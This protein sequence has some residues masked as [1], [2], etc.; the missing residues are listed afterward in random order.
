MSSTIGNI[1]AGGA[2]V[3]G[4]RPPRPSVPVNP[5]PA[6]P[7]QADQ[8]PKVVAPKPVAIQFNPAEVRQNLK[9]AV[10]LLNQQMAATNRGLGFRM[11]DIMNTPVVTVRSD[12]TG[13]VVRQI[14]NEVVGALPTTLRRSR[15]CFSTAK[16]KFATAPAH[17]QFKGVDT[18]QSLTPTSAPLQLKILC[19]QPA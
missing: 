13:E 3:A 16:H 15:V 17:I 2:G 7:V 12:Q 4:M 1:A 5:H 14:P 18:C 6:A 8:S 9:E 10:S 11:D 19:A